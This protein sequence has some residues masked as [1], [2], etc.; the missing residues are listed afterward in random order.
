M[1]LPSHLLDERVCLLTRLV[2]RLAVH[3]GKGHV[4]DCDEHRGADKA[5]ET[6]V[7]DHVDGAE[8]TIRAEHAGGEG[9]VASERAG[10]VV[11]G[12]VKCAELLDVV[13]EGLGSYRGVWDG[14]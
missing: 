6:R 7:G 4:D 3:R 2:P 9:E 1:V 8:I 11:Q 13:R 5:N 14:R 12:I 10:E